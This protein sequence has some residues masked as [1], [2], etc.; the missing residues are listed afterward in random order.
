C[1]NLDPGESRSPR[2][3][4]E[5]PLSPHPLRWRLTLDSFIDVSLVRFFND[6]SSD[7]L[8]FLPLHALAAQRGDGLRPELLELFERHA[9]SEASLDGLTEPIEAEVAYNVVEVDPEG[10]AMKSGF[11]GPADA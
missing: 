4:N 8:P 3:L 1:H 11:P 10:P 5:T 2:T 6:W 7:M 9:R